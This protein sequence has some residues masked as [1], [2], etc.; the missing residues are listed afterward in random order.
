M[1]ERSKHIRRQMTRRIL[2]YLDWDEYGALLNL[3]NIEKRDMRQQ[4]ALL[5]RRELI[6]LGLMPA[7]PM[8][9]DNQSK[10]PSERQL[11]TAD[12]TDG[13]TVEPQRVES[14]NAEHST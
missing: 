12:A 4:A 10:T 11:S 5:L 14:N 2:V 8:P 13:A 3:S 9:I 6:R 7:D 1:M